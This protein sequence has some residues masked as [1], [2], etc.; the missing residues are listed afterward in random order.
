M[1]RFLAMSLLLLSQMSWAE[2]VRWQDLPSSSQEAL[3]NLKPLPNASNIG[4]PYLLRTKP[5]PSSVLNVGNNCHPKNVK[6]C[7]INTK[8][9]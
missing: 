2:G 1:K 7:L 4:N 9:S 6:N 5:K 3:A 8:N